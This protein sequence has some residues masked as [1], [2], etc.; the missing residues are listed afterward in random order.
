[1]SPRLR[2]SMLPIESLLRWVGWET[3]KCRE[4]EVL[5][6]EGLN[7]LLEFACDYIREDL[8]FAVGVGAEA[9]VGRDAIFVDDAE[10]AQLFMAWGR[11]PGNGA[12]E[13]VLLCG[14]LGQVC[15]RGNGEGV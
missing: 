2:I 6:Y 10:G 4:R 5:G 1:M 7:V 13:S 15:I 3:S 8:E 14:K 11:M 12:S 9:V